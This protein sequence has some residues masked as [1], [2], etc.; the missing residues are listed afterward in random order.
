MP[1]QFLDRP[2]SCW[3][4]VLLFGGCVIYVLIY[5]VVIEILHQ[6]FWVQ[7]L[8]LGTMLQTQYCVEILR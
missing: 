3:I 4:H 2:S 7:Q 5:I 6:S 8:R 1:Y